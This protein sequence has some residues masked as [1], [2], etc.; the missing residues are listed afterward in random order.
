MTDSISDV[1]ESDVDDVLEHP[2]V[3]H[4]SALTAV[5]C[6]KCGNY[7]CPK[8]MIFTP[9]GVRCKP[10]ARLRKA[11]QFD[12]GASRLALAGVGALATAAL[13]WLV[14]LQ[15]PF[16]V[17]LLAIFVGLAVGEVASRLARRRVS[18]PL[19]IIVGVDIVLGFVAVRIFQSMAPGVGLQPS[20][21]RFAAVST[22][23]NDPFSLILL[24]LAIFAGV[25][26]LRR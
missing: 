12:V 20:V 1:Q 26:R 5:A 14:V 22:A 4:R 18:R 3:N 19:E 24:G 23:L 17:W 8:C 10:C 11:P 21:T 9:V 2:C 6:G 25:T 7:I 15:V 16:L 13:A